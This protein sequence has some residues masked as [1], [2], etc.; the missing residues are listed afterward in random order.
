MSSVLAGLWQ[1]E[2]GWIPQT[3]HFDV[4]SIERTE[5]KELCSF[6]SSWL[7]LLH[8]GRKTEPL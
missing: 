3:H 2:C 6:P 8:F 4:L 5:F 7:P 1:L